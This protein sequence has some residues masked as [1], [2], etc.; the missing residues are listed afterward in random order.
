M[1]IGI[2]PFPIAYWEFQAKSGE[3]LDA[4]RFHENEARFLIGLYFDL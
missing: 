4:A 1:K 3:W 2:F